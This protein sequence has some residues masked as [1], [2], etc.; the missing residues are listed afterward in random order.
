MLAEQ[1]QS[2][3]IDWSAALAQ[4]WKA[5][6]VTLVGANETGGTTGWIMTSLRESTIPFTGT[7]NVVSRR[8][9]TVYGIDAATSLAEVEG[10]LGIVWLLVGAEA[11]LGLLDELAERRPHAVIVFSGGFAEAGDHEAQATLREWSLRTG[12]PLFGPQSLGFISPR[13]NVNV[14]DG[15][16]RGT[17]KPGRTVLM[18]QSGSI[19][20]S[21]GSAASEAGIGLHTVFALGG[22]AVMDYLTLGRALLAD[23]VGAIGLYLEDVGDLDEFARFVQD[24]TRAGVPI[25][26]LLA[27]LSERGQAIAASHTGAIGSPTRLILG[28]AEQFGVVVVSTV[29]D[30]VSSLSALESAGYRRFGRGRVGVFAGSGGALI[31]LSDQLAKTDIE[32]PP[33]ERDTAVTLLGEEEVDMVYNP[34]DMGA[35]LLGKPDEF[36]RRVE[37]IVSD[38]NIDIAVHLFD[39]PDARIP[40]HIR[41]T[42][43]AIDATIAH[44]KQPMLATGV[45]RR[46]FRVP[47]QYGPDVTIA[48]GAAQTVA[49]IVALSTWS[50]GDAGCDDVGSYPAPAGGFTHV[51][52]DEAVRALLY[53]VP[54]RWPGERRVGRTADVAETLAGARFPLVAKADAGLAHRANAG[55]VLTHIPDLSAAV[56]ATDYL[57]A[58]FD[59]DVTFSER[60][61]FEE[62]LFVGLSRS[63]DGTPFLAV[64][65]GGSGVEDKRVGVRLLPLS[66]RQR[67][68]LLRRY[69]PSVAEHEGFIAVVRALEELMRDPTI[70]SL[71]LN[72][73]VIDSD[74][75]I[76]ALD[77]KAHLYD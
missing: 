17:P 39:I 6:A 33:F 26:L 38:P 27:G 1:V 74:G 36:Q 76:A 45:D 47:D 65:P 49:K 46:E 24:A 9:G 10:E 15:R 14:L 35:G 77:V 68:D 22:S 61:S 7:I 73:L 29:D 32:L 34:F 71:D 72:P 41:W 66:D 16:L 2:A 52:T 44:G 12:I 69:A 4:T 37:A 43:D 64:G 63:A 28:I 60:I 62:E 58:L 53:G 23:D 3:G 30:M 70:E 11:V 19:A 8:G 55:G 48:F 51:V 42:Q 40:A 25:V 67:D 56:A 5:P 54:V 75:A 20:I 18:A 59:S 31:S 21:S 50:R 57:R 13:H